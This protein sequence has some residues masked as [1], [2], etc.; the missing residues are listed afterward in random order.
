MRAPQRVHTKASISSP[1]RS[2][3]AQALYRG[4]VTPED[5]AAERATVFDYARTHR[6]DNRA[7]GSRLSERPGAECPLNGRSAPDRERQTE[8][9]V[10]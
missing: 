1:C 6:L 2:K 4:G 5:A 3:D 10:S 9:L 8:H 7:D